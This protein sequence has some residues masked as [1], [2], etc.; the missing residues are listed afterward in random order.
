[1]SKRRQYTVEFKL[2]VV[3]EYLNGD[4]RVWVVAERNGIPTDI[5]KGGGRRSQLLSN[6]LALYRRGLLH[7][8]NAIAVSHKAP[9]VVRAPE[10]IY[11]VGDNTY[12]TKAAAR[13]AAM[14]LATEQPGKHILIECMVRTTLEKL[15]MVIE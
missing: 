12:T 3:Q 5:T 7:M 6:W 15:C 14:Q 11:M 10:S 4:D 9:A 2:K 8:D 1:M 13:S